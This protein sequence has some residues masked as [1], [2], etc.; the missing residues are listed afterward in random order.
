[1]GNVDSV[2]ACFNDINTNNPD[3][4]VLTYEVSATGPT[5]FLDL[6]LIKDDAWR[7]SGLLSTACYQKPVNRY[8][9]LPFLTEMPRHVLTGFIH[10]E[11]I[12]YIKRCSN[13]LDFFGMLRLFWTR[14]SVRGYPGPYLCETFHSAADYSQR[15]ALLAQM[16]AM[17]TDRP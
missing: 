12:R 13:L 5:V 4:L 14:L 10:G 3:G 2:V 15:V 1:M 8:L 17:S 6:L 11:I 9:Y 7:H 16:G